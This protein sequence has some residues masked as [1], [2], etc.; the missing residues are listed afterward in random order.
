MTITFPLIIKPDLQLKLL[1][2]SH[3]ETMHRVIADN[4]EH[5]DQWLRW[6]ARMQSLDNVIALIERFAHK[7]AE[8]DG[9][10]AGL[11][12]QNQF[13]GGIVC[14][15]INR[16]SHKTEIGYWL[17]ADYVGK[18]LVTQACRAV[19]QQLFVNNGG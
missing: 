6:S 11:W 1:D 13:A 10:H 14:H 4:R 12:Y 17:G 18:G 15:Y 8:G 16:E 19:I 3:A 5:L 7:Y 9:F 2:L